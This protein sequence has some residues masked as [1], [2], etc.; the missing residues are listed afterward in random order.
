M[1]LIIKKTDMDQK[2]LDVFKYIVD[3]GWWNFRCITYKEIADNVLKSGSDGIDV[4]FPLGKIEQY[5]EDHGLPRLNVI[6]V[7]KNT[8]RPGSWAYESENEHTWRRRVKEV[9]NFNWNRVKFE[10]E[11]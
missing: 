5:C 10:G 3:H 8:R 9:F 6:V 11:N 7:N 1:P 4:R 2:S